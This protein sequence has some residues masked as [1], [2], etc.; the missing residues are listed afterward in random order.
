M[1][2]S[3][4]SLFFLYLIVIM[5]SESFIWTQYVPVDKHMKTTKQM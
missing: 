2:E 1:I 3:C 5:C 4:I